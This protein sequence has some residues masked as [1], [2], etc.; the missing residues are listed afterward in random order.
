MQISV[1]R[2]GVLELD[3]LE[4]DPSMFESNSEES[5]SLLTKKWIKR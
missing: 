5:Y 2:L 4:I 3:E 1:N